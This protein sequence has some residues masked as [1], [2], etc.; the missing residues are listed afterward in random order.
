M[1]AKLFGR[2]EGSGAKKRFAGTGLMSGDAIGACAWRGAFPDLADTV[3]IKHVMELPRD[4]GGPAT[5][6]RQAWC[7][8]AAILLDGL[9]SLVPGLVAP[10][11]RI[12]SPPASVMVGVGAGRSDDRMGGDVAE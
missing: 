4:I 5:D 3:A 2:V 7:K 9:A 8:F 10:T 12:D 11:S 1:Q 6:P